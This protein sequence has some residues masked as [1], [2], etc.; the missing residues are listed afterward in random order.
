MFLVPE[1]T[2]SLPAESASTEPGQPSPSASSCPT[3]QLPG[4][5]HDTTQWSCS[6]FQRVWMKT[7]L[8]SLG[9]WPGSLLASNP[10]KMVSLWRFPPQPELIDTISDFPSPK[11][12]QLHPFFIWKP[13]NAI[14]ARLR[15]NYALP[16]VKGCLQPQVT[17]AGVGRPRV[18][19]GLTGQYYLFSSRL[20]CKVCGRKWFADNPQWLQ[21][22]PK[23]FSN[24]LPATLTYK[25]AICKSV[26]DELRRTGNSPTEMANQIMEMMHLKYER[27]NL[28][29]LLSCQNIMDGE[30]GRYG[31]QTITQFIPQEGQPMPF[32]D[33][34]DSEGWNGISVSAHYLTDCLLNEYQHQEGA[35]NKL[36]Q[37]TFGQTFRS[38]HN[39]KVARKVTFSSGAMSSYAVMNEHWMIISWVMVQSET[40]KSLRPMYE[41]LSNRYDSAVMEKAQYH[42][43]NRDCCAA[44]TVAECV[45]GEHLEWEAWQ[46]SA[47]ITAEATSGNFL[48]VCASRDHYNMDITIKLDLF[49]CMR[50]FLRECVSEHH[51][52]YGS[53]AQFL[54]AAFSVVDQEDLQ[55]LKDAYTFC[56]IQPANPTKQHIH[57]H[58]RTKIPGPDEVIQRVEAVLKHFHLAEDPNGTRLFKAS[59]LKAWRIQRVHILRGCLSDPEV[60]GGIL[61]RHGGTVQLN[62]VKGEGA[63]V[64]VW[65]PIRGTSQQEGY[66][67][68]QAQWVTGTRV[69]PELFQAQAMTGVARWNYQRLVDLK[70]PGVSLP[71]AFD[72]VL[73]ADLNAASGHVLGTVKYPALQVCGRDTGERFGLE[74]AEP[75]T[76]PVPLQWDKHRTKTDS[77][78]A[79]SPP[80]QSSSPVTQAE[81]PQPPSTS[82][83]PADPV[84]ETPVPECEPYTSQESM[85]PPPLPLL[86]SPTAAHTGSVKSRGRVYVLDHRRWPAPMRKVID[87]LLDK[88]HGQ[89]DML[90]LVDQ[91]Y[92]ALLLNSRTDP[93][94]LL[95]PTTEIHISQYVKHQS[96]LTT[97]SSS[98]N[99]TMSETTTVS[100][101]TVP[102]V[103]SS[104]PVQP[105][106]TISITPESIERIVLSI[107]EKQ[108][109]QQP[110]DQKKTQTKTCLS[111]GQPKSKNKNDGSSFHFFYQ[112][113][114]IRY[115]YCST[116]VFK[117]YA[118]EGLTNPKMPFADFAKTD[119]FQR[120]LDTT[121][122]KVEEKGQQKRKR[123][124]PEPPPEPPSTGR[125]CGFCRKELKQGPNSPHIHTGFPGIGG[126]YIYCPA[127]VHSLFKD[128]GME[129]EMTWR[130]FQA[131]P[132]YNM[133]RERWAAEKGRR[134]L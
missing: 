64:P 118:A 34:G 107:M 111:C 11:Y 89:K 17:S 71:A 3:P 23:R 10:M 130:E 63:K 93:N 58:C 131:S 126:K 25:K 112:Q 68:H 88:H 2:G 100:I 13:E 98:P 42:W 91:E 41:G 125:K 87:D 77:T 28:A 123:T 6:H 102:T 18:I 74:Y 51:P 39:R 84:D 56:G 133:E 134:N 16:C 15:N 67:F 128:K 12:F 81:D 55:R 62:N 47:V 21:K 31:Q 73:I 80:P 65:I 38:V 61:Y 75:G 50:R 101:E 132:F 99:T 106:D 122:R 7:E 36:L 46:T 24:M 72:P 14:M 113:G 32:G 40:E 95:H 33:Y 127:K 115:F 27:A 43:V 78:P 124:E 92:G 117:A 86:S 120:E 54:S 35:I 5:D 79:L 9:L 45:P 4:Y 22:L 105:P 119:F 82:S 94:S 116:K 97:T 59:M 19:V 8:E 30:S 69:S 48:N 129:R 26:I 103:N 83:P 109:Q 85:F 66:H 52:L 57:E 20:C 53:F 114:P 37:G 29:Y 1:A 49:S 60:E 44:F 76:R 121:K 96:K 90:S 70:Q 108:Q 104:A 110:Q